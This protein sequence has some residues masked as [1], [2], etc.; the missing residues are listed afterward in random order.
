MDK[1]K[2]I[3]KKVLI[4]SLGLFVLLCLYNAYKYPIW[5]QIKRE[6]HCGTV[7]KK[8]ADEVA[9]KYGVR[10]QLYLLVDFDNIAT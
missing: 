1:I 6:V 2:S 5:N 10:T 4:F 3:T 7:L 9:I 8:S